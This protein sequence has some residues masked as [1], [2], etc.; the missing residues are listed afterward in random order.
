MR[1]EETQNMGSL[2]GQAAAPQPEGAQ[3]APVSNDW[4]GDDTPTG[5]LPVIADL[6]RSDVADTSNDDGMRAVMLAKAV[7]YEIIPR[8]MLVHRVPQ[9]CAEHPLTILQARVSSEDVA[10]FAELVLHENDYVVRDCVISLR[11]RG[12]PVESIFL[13]LLAP[14]ARLLGEMW[15]RDLCTFSEV[16]VGLGRLQKVLRENS[17]TFGQFN[18]SHHSAQGRRILLMPCPGEHHTFGLSVVAEFFH[19]AGWDVVTSFLA[20]DAAAVMVKKEWYDVVGFSLGSATGSSRLSAAIRLVR[21][22]SQN[23]K[24]SIICGGP[25]FQ[26]HPE[27]ATEVAADAIIINGSEAPDQANKLVESSLLRI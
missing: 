12:V 7:E 4:T 21:V 17:V 9:D 1:A 24:I 11:D 23:P 26:W 19:R 2:S 5:S 25:A 8:L 16:T 18:G 3:A 6:L 15:D 22:V 27:A 13:D 10:L 14:V 20:T